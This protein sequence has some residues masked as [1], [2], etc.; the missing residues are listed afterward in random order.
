MSTWQSLGKQR[1]KLFIPSN[2]SLN[3]K[4]NF[5]GKHMRETYCGEHIGNPTGSIASIRC[6]KTKGQFCGKHI[7]YVSSHD[8]GM[9]M[10]YCGELNVYWVVSLRNQVVTS[11]FSH[12]RCLVKKFVLKCM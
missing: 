7:V 11:Q 1:A 2:I 9:R 10:Y 3:M 6:L 8:V 12:C 4:V 5:C